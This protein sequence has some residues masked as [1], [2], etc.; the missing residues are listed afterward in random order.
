MA[1]TTNNSSNNNSNNSNAVSNSSSMPSNT[2]SSNSSTSS[3]AT[4]GIDFGTSRCCVAVFRNGAVHTVPNSRGER[5]TPSVVAFTDRSSLAGSAAAGQAATNAR[6]TVFE[7]KQLLGQPEPGGDNNINN[8]SSSSTTTHHP[9]ASLHVPPKGKSSTNLLGSKRLTLK[10][11]HRR[12][13][14]ELQPEVV[15]ALLLRHLKQSAEQFLNDERA[16]ILGKAVRVT[17]AV[18]AVPPS[19]TNSQR[20]A[21]LDAAVLAGLEVKR[22]VGEPTCAALAYT[23]AHPEIV[24]EWAAA[25]D[26]TNAASRGGVGGARGV[27]GGAGGGAGGAAEAAAAGGAGAK[28]SAQTPSVR[29]VMVLDMGA[30]TTNASCMLLEPGLC[31]MLAT[32]TCRVGGGHIDRAMVAHFVRQIRQ[33][34]GAD[35]AA[36]DGS[37]RTSPR[38]SPKPPRSAAVGAAAVGAAAAAG[39]AAG[40]AGASGNVSSSAAPLAANE[41]ALLRLQ[42]ACERIKIAL[43]SSMKA[44]ETLDALFPGQPEFVCSMTRAELEGLSASIMRDVGR[45]V[46]RALERA[47][48]RAAQIGDVILTG[49]CSRM[50]ALQ[51]LV[52]AQLPHSTIDRSLHPDE[53][54]ATGAALHAAMLEGALD[55]VLAWD[56]CPTTINLE[57]V[58]GELV[59]MLERYEQSPSV[60]T[61]VLEGISS[62]SPDGHFIKVFESDLDDSYNGLNSTAVAAGYLGSYN[63]VSNSLMSLLQ[64]QQSPHP[65][66]L[67]SS[68]Q[69]SRAH[70]IPLG[71][72]YIPRELYP[73]VKLSFNVSKDGLLTIQATSVSSP[74]R[75]VEL[76]NASAFCVLSDE[77]IQALTAET[78]QFGREEL[79][80]RKRVELCE[81]LEARITQAGGQESVQQQQ[82]QQLQSR[83][84]LPSP[85]QQQQQQQLEQQKQKLQSLMNDMRAWLDQNAETATLAELERQA[86]QFDAAIASTTAA[87]AAAAAAAASTKTTTTTTTTSDQ[88]SE[89]TTSTTSA[90]ASSLLT[91][92]SADAA[93]GA[94]PAVAARRR[95][96]NR[97][98]SDTADPNLAIAASMRD[99][100]A[101]RIEGEKLQAEVNRVV[102]SN[103][104]TYKELVLVQFRLEKLMEK[105][106]DV[107]TCNYTLLRERRK[108]HTRFVQEMLRDVERRM[109]RMRNAARACARRWLAR[110]RGCPTPKMQGWDAALQST[111]AFKNARQAL[112]QLRALRALEQQI[113][114]LHARAAEDMAAMVAQ[115]A[116]LDADSEHSQQAKDS[117][118]RRLQDL[119]ARWGGKF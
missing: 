48:V 2:P 85:R 33:G 54:V 112:L 105:I 100:K 66:S 58:R 76:E 64:S 45:T 68:Q 16:A 13:P 84:P 4:I 15:A 29:Y 23:Y 65:S 110:V 74:H 47:G 80:E 14:R 5:L 21:L 38:T 52:R 114:A 25:A 24:A 117:L 93:D 113:A 91:S 36:S 35:L 19:F 20:Q 51:A 17:E 70:A 63:N 107:Q 56:C 11:C 30:G 106:D 22:L 104:T 3:T 18:I 41:R 6:N 50:P 42:R 118:A 95:T 46:E 59:P 115:L 53:A 61:Q 88:P 81:Q 94:G 73:D 31:Q 55:M 90:S 32:A 102:G 39:A 116:A 57:T 26:D 60:R 43:S 77:E 9:S 108:Q 119:Q 27:G 87:I 67:H 44:S 109:S 28:A 79:E 72:Y 103:A 82:Q 12:Q 83:S 69:P 98:T 34:F 49:G 10:V 62:T 7:I 40:A 78:E 1:S 37:A 96:T 97:R 101:L 99:L 71:K 86:A 89:S 111:P 8:N 75:T 92:D